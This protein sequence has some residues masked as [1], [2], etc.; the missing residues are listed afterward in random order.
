[1]MKLLKLR[2]FNL[3]VVSSSSLASLL[4]QDS[5][6]RTLFDLP[7]AEDIS[8]YTSLFSVS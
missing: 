2:L 6:Q 8:L 7:I 4:L 1:M 3:T 5:F